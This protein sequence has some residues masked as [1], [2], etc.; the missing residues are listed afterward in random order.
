MLTSSSKLVV[1]LEIIVE[2]MIETPTMN[3]LKNSVMIPPMVVPRLR[4]ELIR[5]SLRK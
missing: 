1:T 4:R 5:L 2:N 3:R